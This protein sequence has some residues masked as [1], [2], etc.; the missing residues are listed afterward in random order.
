MLRSKFGSLILVLALAGSVAY[1]K[2][3]FVGGWGASAYQYS[4]EGSHTVYA[5]TS[6]CG[7][8][9]S[10]SNNVLLPG[11]STTIDVWARFPAD[12]YAFASS[13][14]DISTGLPGWAQVSDGVIAD[15]GVAGASASQLHQPFV[16]TFADPSNPLRIWSGEYQ[17]Q[18]FEPRLV[19]V[20][21]IPSAFSYY[22]SELTASS[23]ECEAAAGR[24]WL[25]VNPLT[26]G[27]VLVA[28]GEGTTIELLGLDAFI[29]ESDTQTILIGELYPA[30]QKVRMRPNRPLTNLTV[31]VGMQ[32]DG[33]PIGS[34]VITY[35][36]LESAAYEMY[37]YWAEADAYEF[38]FSQAAG[39][40]YS[41]KLKST[42]GDGDGSVWLERMPNTFSGELR[43]GAQADQARAVSRV[44]FDR[45]V[46]AI[47]PDG[48]V[49]KVDAI[50]VHAVRL[51]DA[52]QIQVTGQACEATGADRVVWSYPDSP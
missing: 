36:Q 37:P 29:A 3:P 5:S 8:A 10:A 28:P 26:V 25:Y 45:P 42:E 12:G 15:T 50:E 31:E 48:T 39:V 35:T 23:A 17:P 6:P 27:D 18:S 1:A 43:V 40:D 24:Q 19:P 38:R 7:L 16:G 33:A 46:R 32:E 4:F 30:V 44:E 14:F 13:E 20:E 9:L 2:A 52:G 51:H 41:L 34:V 22:P 21:A 49:L 11:E 47:A